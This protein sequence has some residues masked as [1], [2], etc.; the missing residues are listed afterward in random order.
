[1]GII[2][3]IFYGFVG[4]F[5]LYIVIET[6]VRK[7]INSSIIGQFIEKKYGIKEDKKS[8]LDDDLDNDK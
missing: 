4:L 3:S 2:L 5:I 6:A 7:G 8:F 1:M